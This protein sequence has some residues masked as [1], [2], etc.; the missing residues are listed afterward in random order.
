MASA[1]VDAI[2]AGPSGALSAD[3]ARTASAAAAVRLPTI[4]NE[5]GYV[6]AGGLISYGFDRK[7]TW[8]RLATY[9]VR[10]FEGAKPSD[11]PVEQ[12]INYL[13]AVNLRTAKSL[14]LTIPPSVLF[15]AEF[16]VE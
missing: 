6:E 4:Y 16:V 15:R 10:I 1:G 9:A 12:T 7:A 14:G 11:L 13:T 5:Q 8:E 3:R 2:V